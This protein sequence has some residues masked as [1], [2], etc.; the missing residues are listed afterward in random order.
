MQLSNIKIISLTTSLVISFIIAYF[1][2]WKNLVLAWSTM[3]DYSH[4]FLIIPICGYI[5]F[6]KRQKLTRVEIKPSGWG[7]VLVTLSILLYLFSHI[8]EIVTLSS[9]SMIVLLLGI[10]IYL[11]G[12]TIAKECLF[13]LFLLL[14]MIPIPSQIYSAL[15]IPLQLFVSHIS[16]W[17]A[18]MLALPACREGNIIQIPDHTLQVVSACSGLR[19]MISLL[20]LCAVFAHLTLKSNFLKIILFLSGIPVSIFVNIIRII[21]LMLAYYYFDYDL[22]NGPIHSVFGSIIFIFAIISIVL[23]K[24]LLS[25]WDASAAQE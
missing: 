4:G 24:G 10:I 5:L 13:P 23:I 21:I 9:L 1:P 15:T 2:V 18:S 19:S 16:V 14:F 8:A 20:T 22:T 12:F 25:I 11:Y 7:F 3:D 17:A 6:Q